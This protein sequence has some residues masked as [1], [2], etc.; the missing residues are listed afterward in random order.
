MQQAIEL[1]C[2][3]LTLR[4]MIHIPE[5]GKSKYPFVAIYHGFTGN[6]MEPQFMF[7]RLSRELEKAGVGSVRFDFSGSGESDGLFEEMSVSNEIKEAKHIFKF[8][9]ELEY[10][11]KNNL[12]MVGLSMG[13]LVAS[14]A[15]PEVDRVKALV[16]WAPAGNMAEIAEYASQK[17]EYYVDEKG[18]IDIGGLWLG[19]HFL[20]DVKGIDVYGRAVHYKGDVLLVHGTADATVPIQASYKYKETYG[21]KAQLIEI[22]GADHTFQRMDWKNELIDTTIDFI[23]RHT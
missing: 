9:S 20:E 6:K 3:G 19:P 11:D 8:M 10:A 14:V 13:G 2:D 21:E 7:V 18:R 16:L 5:L 15:A 17:N 1:R 4:G 12:F 22:E 23:A